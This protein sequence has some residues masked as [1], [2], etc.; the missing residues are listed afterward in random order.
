MKPLYSC[1]WFDHAGQDAAE[2]YVSLFKNSKMHTIERYTE[3]GQEITGGEPGKVMVVNYTLMGQQFLNLN[4][5]PIFQHT[6]SF[7]NFVSLNSSEEI[8][9]LWNALSQ[10]GEVRMPLQKYDWSEKYGWVK[11]RFGVEWQLMLDAQGTERI[12]PAFLFTDKMFG[13]GEAAINYW[14]GLFPN[15]KIENIFRDENT[16]TVMY[17]DFKLNDKPFVLMEGPGEHNTAFNES[18]S[19]TVPC[20]DQKEID[21]F[22]NEMTKNGGQESQCGWLKDKF[23]VSWQIVPEDMERIM[24]A[25]NKEAAMGAMLEM[26]KLDIAKLMK[27]A[28]L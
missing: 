12:C 26:K 22:W 20:K 2:F 15:S 16:K 24:G 9:K 27:A 19:I 25:G 21:F 10:K 14:T 5:G 11:D 17:C 3:T 13:K 7:S 18:Y 23:G 6:Q 8:D 1:L 28:E 4:G